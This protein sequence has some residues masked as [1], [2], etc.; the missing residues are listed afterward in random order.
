[1]PKPLR[2]SSCAWLLPCLP[3]VLSIGCG[4]ESGAGNGGAGGMPAG[5]IGG[6]GGRGTGGSGTSSGGSTGSGTGGAGG[7]STAG[8]GGS[9][10]AGSGG[11][12]AG[13]SGTGGSNTEPQPT[14]AGSP[15]DMGMTPP[16]MPP[17]TAEE[18]L[19][20]CVR[21]VQVAGQDA[22]APALSGAMPGDCVVLA[23]GT[24]SFP[25]IT[26]KG[27]ADKPVVIRA[28]NILKAVVMTGDVTIA[29][30]A[31][32]VVEGLHFRSPGQIKMSDCDHCRI[33]RF[34]VERAMA[35]GEIDWITV[36]GTSKHC[37]IDHNDIGPQR[38]IGNLI[39][40]S[41][42]GNQIVQHT[43]IDH[44]YLHDVTYGGGNGWELIRNGLSGWTFSSAHTIIERNLFVRGDSDP[45][46]ISV[47]SSD[48]IIRY[49][50]MR[51]TSGQFTLRHGNRTEVY[52]NYILGDGRPGSTGFRVYGGGHKIYN[53][54]MAGLAGT[55]INI[56]SG[57]TNDT[58][59]AL[60]DHKQTYDILVVFNTVV[61]GRGI[62]LGS[63]K[64][65]PPRNITVAYNLIQGDVSAIAGTTMKS[66][67]NIVTGSASGFSGG[68][69]NVDPK[70]TK[71]GDIMRIGAG[72]PVI[73]GAEAMFPFVTEDAD[74]RPR[75]GKLD[76]GAEELGPGPA[77]YGLLTEKDVGPLAP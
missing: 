60:T 33:S 63:G 22:L 64:P 65:L 36:S 40:I 50:T 68:I 51:A 48:N 14:D 9:A 11:S 57:T 53:N 19:P 23:D 15:T 39:M 18:P 28:A 54:Y 76:I 26:A 29:G 43:R 67:G 71:V 17:P 37:R 38:Q 74:G 6:A 34:R 58:T 24:Y 32:A 44:N 27:T 30:G 47:K 70:L 72:S 56:D 8:S 42:A 2:M 59:G 46:T 21:T 5:G 20:P 45:E 7:S 41:G 1:M 4:T 77:K 73:D 49:N 62:A 13:G 31:Y 61:G 12:G 25:T 35:S 3:L 10:T 16:T 75:M 66:M 52:G 55:G 69:M